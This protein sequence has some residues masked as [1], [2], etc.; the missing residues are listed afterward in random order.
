MSWIMGRKLS[1]FVVAHHIS[2][3]YVCFTL[4]NSSA[5]LTEPPERRMR[6]FPNDIGTRSLFPRTASFLNIHSDGVINPI[7]NRWI[8]G[9]R[10]LLL[11]GSSNAFP[12]VSEKSYQTKRIF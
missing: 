5:F 3:N 11:I 7:A 4:I 10:G 12:V 1:D 9:L 8:P 2:S 6:V